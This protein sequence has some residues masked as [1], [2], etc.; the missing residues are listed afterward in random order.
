MT[1]KFDQCVNQDT[2]FIFQK[3]Q[4]VFFILVCNLHNTNQKLHYGNEVLIP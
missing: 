4:L 2:I 3:V 1:I